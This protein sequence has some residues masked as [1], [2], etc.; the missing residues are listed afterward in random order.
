VYPLAK[1]WASGFFQLSCNVRPITTPADIKGLKI[2][3]VPAPITVDAFRALGA[4]PTPV[5]GGEIY[6]AMQTHLVDGGE[7]TLASAES[8]KFY[9][10]QKYISI[11]NIQFSSISILA[12]VAAMQRLPKDVR[13]IVEN[14]LNDAAARAHDDL[15]RSESDLRKTLAGHGTILNQ[16]DIASFRAALKTEGM[17]AKWRD[18]FGGEAWAVLEKSVGKLG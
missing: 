2:R 4:I 6:T 18:Q 1:S 5:D 9:E 14:N 8:S 17:Y 12:N 16:A 15:V 11:T 13:T 3:V 7:I 10:V